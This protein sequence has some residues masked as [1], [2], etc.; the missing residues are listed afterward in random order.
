MENSSRKMEIFLT[1]YKDWLND[2]DIEFIVTTYDVQP[3]TSSSG[4]RPVKSFDES[5][6]KSKMRKIQ[7]LLQGS[8]ASELSY[9]AEVSIRASGSRNAASIIKE[10]HSASPNRA[11]RLKAMWSKQQNDMRAYSSDEA[12]AIYRSDPIINSFREIPQKSSKSIPAEVMNLLKSP[13][14]QMQP[15]NVNVV[16]NHTEY[17][18]EDPSDSFFDNGESDSE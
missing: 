7:H 11:T 12:L 6:E 13:T 3:S 1:K 16:F 9:A 8:S 5:S 17:T 10:L 14:S 4:G 2:K 18:T 15:H